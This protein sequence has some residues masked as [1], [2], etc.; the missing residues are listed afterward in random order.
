MRECDSVARG[1]RLPFERIHPAATGSSH[2]PRCAAGL[3]QAWPTAARRRRSPHPP[4]QP[5]RRI[6]RAGRAWRIRSRISRATSASRGDRHARRRLDR[7]GG[8]G[9]ART[10]NH[11]VM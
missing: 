10:C 11:T 9:R 4:P 3:N 5:R 2:S 8:P 6:I 7:P 1:A